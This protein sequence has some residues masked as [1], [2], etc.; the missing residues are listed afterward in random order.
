MP[1]R[2]ARAPQRDEELV[3]ELVLNLVLELRKKN[4]CYSCTSVLEL[5]K[6]NS[7]YSCTSSVRVLELVFEL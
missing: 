7:C 3:L 5:C 1:R 6:K 2:V 4:S